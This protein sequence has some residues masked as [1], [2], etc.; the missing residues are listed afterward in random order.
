MYMEASTV[1][2]DGEVTGAMPG[3]SRPLGGKMSLDNSIPP[4]H[5]AEL[6]ELKEGVARFGKS[7]NLSRMAPSPCPVPA[8]FVNEL[9]DVPVI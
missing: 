7:V 8:N 5:A 3:P 2:Q 9:K 1:E 4:V 6:S